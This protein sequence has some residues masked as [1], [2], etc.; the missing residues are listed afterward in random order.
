MAGSERPTLGDFMSTECFRYLRIFGEEAAGRSFIVY[1]GKQRGISLQDALKGLSADN[2]PEIVEK[3][4]LLVG[5]KGTRLCVVDQFEATD[6][7]YRFTISESA[8]SFGMRTDEPNCAYT[9]GVFL[10]ITET[11]TGRRFTVNES[12]CEA[13]G[14]AHCIYNLQQL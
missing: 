13:T 12:E 6:G 9:M 8:C 7:G 2:A 1:A 11:I 3:L 4:N 5:E 10:G 14:H